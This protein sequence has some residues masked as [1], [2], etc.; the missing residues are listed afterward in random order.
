MSERL[1]EW[2]PANVKP[3]LPGWYEREYG[4]EWMAKSHDYWNGRYWL[5]GDGKVARV[6]ASSDMRWRGLA[7]DPSHATHETEALGDKGRSE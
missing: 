3:A 2:F 1:T 6:R 5:V 4:I 7:E